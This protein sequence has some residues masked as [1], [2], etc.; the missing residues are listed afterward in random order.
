MRSLSAALS[1]HLAGEVTTLATLWL[2]TWKNGTVLAFTD[3]DEDIIYS[4][5][6]Y[7]AATGY[8]ASDVAS[9]CTLEVDN[10]DLQGMLA[11]P[12]ITETDLRAGLWDY[13]RVEISIVNYED[14][15]MGALIQRVGHLG[16]VTL[17]R[18]QFKAEL[19][20]L[21]QAYSTSIVEL[22]SP[23][24]RATFG[25]ARCGIVLSGSP[26]A[27]GGSPAQSTVVTGTVGSIGAD[28]VT[29][30]DAARTEHAHGSGAGWFQGGK[31]TWLTGLNVGLS[32]EIKSNTT[33]VL[34]LAL[35][36]SYTV[37]PGDT[38]TLTAGCD[39]LIGTC[40]EYANVVNFRGEPYLRGNDIMI[41]QG[42]HS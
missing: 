20:G 12:S 32:M 35:P 10:L 34:V 39:K 7:H 13:A 6:A 26:N 41:Q 36:M 40:A 17:D 2:I 19:R 11:S 29:I 21:V 28:R 30:A 31:L 16:E 14:L 18:G 38:Y 3:H 42:R 15:T 1:A 27:I 24:C 8:Q 9:T 5:V 23:G 37:A 25:D 4:N 33:G 22:T